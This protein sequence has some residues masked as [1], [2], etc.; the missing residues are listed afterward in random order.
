MNETIDTQEGYNLKSFVAGFGYGLVTVQV[1]VPF[2]I[3]TALIYIAL[4]KFV[5]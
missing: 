1:I 4:T 2:L 5:K 3:V